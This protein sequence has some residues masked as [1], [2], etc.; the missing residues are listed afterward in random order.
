MDV[1]LKWVIIT[2]LPYF[3]RDDQISWKVMT[4]EYRGNKMSVIA[5]RYECKKTQ[6]MAGDI[7]EA[8]LGWDFF[9][10]TEPLHGWMKARDWLI[11]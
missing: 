8:W 3:H 7:G 4:R 2:T 5:E 11:C 10:V 1:D 9:F 6:N